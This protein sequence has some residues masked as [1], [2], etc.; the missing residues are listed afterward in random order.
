MYTKPLDAITFEDI[1]EFIR[2]NNLECTRFDAKRE[3]KNSLDKVLSA[4]PNGFTAN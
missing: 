4:A 1:E 2:D 3:W